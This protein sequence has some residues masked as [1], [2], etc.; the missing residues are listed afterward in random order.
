SR[1]EVL[2]SLSGRL[3][4]LVPRC[5][6][7]TDSKLTGEEVRLCNT[8]VILRRLSVTEVIHFRSTARACRVSRH[9]AR[10][11]GTI[12]RTWS[13]LLTNFFCPPLFAGAFAPAAQRYS[14]LFRF[15]GRAAVAAFLILPLYIGPAVLW[16]RRPQRWYTR[17]FIAGLLLT[18]P[19]ALWTF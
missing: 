4:S 14:P 15:N 2:Q 19:L 3:R 13:V 10:R 6:K 9:G 16:L 5:L 1:E 11:W 12:R 18:I 17:G 8:C 7:R